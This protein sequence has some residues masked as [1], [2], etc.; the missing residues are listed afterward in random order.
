MDNIKINMIYNTD[1]V[2]GMRHMPDGSVDCVVT[3]PPYDSLR[4]YGDAAFNWNLDKAID[5]GRE[6]FRVLKDGGV[7]VWVVGDSTVDGSESLTSFRQAIAFRE[8]GFNVHDTMIYYKDNPCP[9]GGS[10]RYYQA[11]EYMFVFSKGTPKTFNYLTEPRRNK[12]NDKRTKRFKGFQ[13]N[14]DG[15]MTPKM[16][17]INQGDP[18]RRNVWCYS[19]GA[20]DH[21]GHPAVFPINL[22]LDHISTWTNEGDLV[23]DPFMGSGTTAVAAAR[24]NRNFIGFELNED[25]C[26]HANERVSAEIARGGVYD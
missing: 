12:W 14:A 1:C 26:K 24:L 7:C 8:I 13:R 4:N 18:K 21:T 19:L 11:F 2:Q 9:V 16:V 5:V 22:A 15:E 20:S 6:I 3:S 23:L 25:Y 17:N 10:N